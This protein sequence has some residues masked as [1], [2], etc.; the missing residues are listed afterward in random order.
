MVFDNIVDA[1][2]PAITLF[3]CV[4]FT[5]KEAVLIIERFSLPLTNIIIPS[6]SIFVVIPCVKISIIYEIRIAIPIIGAWEWIIV[7]SI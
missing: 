1:M 4:L 7:G 2:C 5:C 6:F 3:N